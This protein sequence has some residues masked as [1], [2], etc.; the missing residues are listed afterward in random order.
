MS[1]L[2]ILEGGTGAST[3]AEART[4]LGLGDAAERDTTVV[5]SGP[6]DVGKIPILN[7]A[8]QL[9]PKFITIESIPSVPEAEHAVEADHALTADKATT[10]TSAT[11]ATNASNADM[12]DGYHA[13]KTPNPN[14]IPVAGVNGKIDA[15]WIP[16]LPASTVNGY[17]PSVVPG[18]SKIP[19]ADEQGRLA[20]GWFPTL[21]AD[22]VD[23]FHAQTTPAANRI[24]VTG[25]DGK[26]SAG[27][28]PPLLPVHGY[29]AFM[30]P[31]SY[32]F[33]IPTGVTTLFV[34]CTGA[35]GGGGGAYK[36][37]TDGGP[38]NPSGFGNYL[39]AGGGG[40]GL[41]QRY[42]GTGANGATGGTSESLTWPALP[43]VWGHSN[44]GG[45]GGYYYSTSGIRGG[46]G[47]PGGT[48]TRYIPVTPGQRIVATVGHWG[49]GGG[50]EAPGAVGQHGWVQIWW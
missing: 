9:D 3:S 10:A 1:I 48:L 47:G 28:L 33:T 27:W 20:T 37:C 29:M 45:A 18:A 31:G 40:G 23:G 4:N 14:T 2:P 22:T 43:G 39:W 36:N 41:G 30:N 50:G 26:L 25:S 11:N 17:A 7:A 12:V 15:A 24:P 21:N 38:G 35:S 34:W 13:N 32:N 44:T 19:V 5:A 8:G 16:T 42:A 49:W 6:A 46:Q